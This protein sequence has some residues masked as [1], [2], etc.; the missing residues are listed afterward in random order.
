MS[1]SEATTIL[2]LL[3]A[4]N[5]SRVPFPQYP[6]TDDRDIQA[7]FEDL[8][9]YDVDTG[10]MVSKVIERG[11]PPISRWRVP[12]KPRKWIEA[13]R[14]RKPQWSE[15]LDTLSM[16]CDGIEERLMLVERLRGVPRR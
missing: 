6:Q 3:E 4:K 9:I 7:L 5:K 13:V 16:V 1:G 15:F 2:G 11:R 14:T 12:I 8:W 10:A